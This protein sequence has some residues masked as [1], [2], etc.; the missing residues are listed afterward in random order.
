MFD[1]NV[2][3]CDFHSGCGWHCD[4]T[5]NGEKVHEVLLKLS[6][7]SSK[8]HC[9]LG[10]LWKCLLIFVMTERQLGYIMIIGVFANVTSNEK[11]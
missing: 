3:A 9:G 7:N 5:E 10:L 6:F 8:Y 1:V 2:V 4:V 11:V